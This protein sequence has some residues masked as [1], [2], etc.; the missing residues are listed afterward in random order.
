MRAIHWI[1]SVHLKFEER[2]ILTA[3]RDGGLQNM[4]V[5]GITTLRVQDES[6]GM[7]RIQFKNDDKR[8]I[9]MQVRTQFIFQAQA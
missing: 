9:Q 5:H 4:E 7:I 3:G 6:C 2:I 8:G 1:C